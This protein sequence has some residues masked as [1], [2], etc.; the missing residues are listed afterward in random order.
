MFRVS[1]ITDLVS[2][3]CCDVLPIANNLAE[4][5]SHLQSFQ[6]KSS[7][8]FSFEWRSEGQSKREDE[9]A[10]QQQC[11]LTGLSISMNQ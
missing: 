5:N 2:W 7:M 6:T 11:C 10:S 9:K 3:N 4:A 1:R 8:K